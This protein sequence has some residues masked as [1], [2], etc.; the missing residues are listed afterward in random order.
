MPPMHSSASIS[1]YRTLK[2]Y[3]TD[4]SCPSPPCAAYASSCSVSDTRRSFRR[5]A[6][7]I[8]AGVSC[9]PSNFSTAPM[10]SSRR[11]VTNDSGRKRTNKAETVGPEIGSRSRRE[12]TCA[13]PCR[14][15]K[16]GDIFAL[17]TSSPRNTRMPPHRTRH[18]TMSLVE[19]RPSTMDHT[20]SGTG[21][22]IEIRRKRRQRTI[23]S[24]A[25]VAL[26]SLNDESE[27]QI[28]RPVVKE[29]ESRLASSK[30]RSLTAAPGSASTSRVP[31]PTLSSA[32][33]ARTT[34]DTFESSSF[35]SVAAAGSA[36]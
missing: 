24:L 13:A 16:A 34:T 30:G 8:M 26:K 21:G 19:H 36:V 1:G 9:S 15:E 17:P 12:T 7:H 4:H 6:P 14:P 35:S 31:T 27:R 2:S 32:F 23:G 33:R 5:F 10:G 28:S 29:H 20:G 25:S 11:L 3:A 18:C 22:D